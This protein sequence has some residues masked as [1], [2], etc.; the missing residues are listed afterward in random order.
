MREQM[1][2]CQKWLADSLKAGSAAPVRQHFEAPTGAL[3]INL[4]DK[5][6]PALHCHLPLTL[7]FGGGEWASYTC[8]M[9]VAVLENI[10]RL[11]SIGIHF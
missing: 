5:T 11:Y 1:Y 9:H 4:G 7:S 2:N 6:L 8:S 3:P 10:S